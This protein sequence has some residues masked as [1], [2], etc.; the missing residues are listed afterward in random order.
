MMQG[1]GAA[2]RL[3]HAQRV[4]PRQGPHVHVEQHQVDL[5]RADD[6]HRLFPAG[7]LAQFDV[8][9]EDLAQRAAELG[10]VVCQK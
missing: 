9:L 1:R 8:R 7:R 3:H 5:P 10:V 4:E 2:Q 6:F